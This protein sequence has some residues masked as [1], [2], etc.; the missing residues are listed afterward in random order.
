MFSGIPNYLLLNATEVLF[1]GRFTS[2]QLMDLSGNLLTEIPAIY[3][4][5]HPTLYDISAF[6]PPEEFFYLMVIKIQ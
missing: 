5:S 3:N 1:P 4:E 2:V 6:I